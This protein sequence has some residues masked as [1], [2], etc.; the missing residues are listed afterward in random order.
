MSRKYSLVLTIL[1]V[2]VLMLAACQPAVPAG[3]E[4]AEEEAAPAEEEEAA[5]AEEE[6]SPFGELEEVP[7]EETVIF[8]N[9]FGRTSLPENFNPYIPG[10][11]TLNGQWQLNLESLFYHNFETGELMPWLAESYEYNDDFTEV[12]I[13]LREGVEWSDGM[14]FTADDVVFTVN[15]MKDTEGLYWSG[16]MSLWVDDV[17]AVD[18][19]TVLFTLTETNPRFVMNFFGVRA[20]DVLFIAPKHIWEGQDPTTFTNYDLEQGWP[21]GTGAYRLV[22]STETE[23]VWDRR[24]DYWAAETGFAPMPAPR[25]AIWV[26]VGT[27]ETRA[28]MLDRNELDGAYALARGTY[29]TLAASNPNIIAWYDEPPYG[30]FDSCARSL[31]FNTAY[32]SVENPDV[33]WAVNYAIDRDSLIDLVYEGITEPQAFASARYTPLEPWFERN[34]DLA[35]RVL[36]YNPAMSEELMIGAGF[37]KDNQGFWVNEDGERVDLPLT[38]YLGSQDSEKALPVIIQQLR[39]A[40]FD[41]SG[42]PQEWAVYI[43]RKSRGD[44]AG[45][46]N[47]CGSVADPVQTLSLFHGKYATP[48]GE[49]SPNIGATSRYANPEFDALVDQLTVMSPDNPMF[50]DLVDEATEIWIDDLPVAGIVQNRYIIPYNETY[51]TNWPTVDNNYIYPLAH[52]FPILHIVLGQLEP[53]S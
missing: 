13:F 48:L 6:S 18:D 16:E 33:R 15:M 20:W 19:H 5:P 38:T 2:F 51:W 28:A 44:I 36:Q 43:D 45:W 32:P 23:T 35:D 29:E 34:Q 40:G 11:Y 42:Q 22:R 17:E 52:W 9:V 46:Y 30:Y 26:F 41:A 24:D 7:R 12:T 27:E 39:D 4:E 8:D 3:E 31:V 47:F 25:R 14:P 21:V 50:N 49:P 1:T 53:A 37:T 10:H